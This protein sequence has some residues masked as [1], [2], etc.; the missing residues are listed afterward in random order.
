MLTSLNEVGGDRRPA[1]SLAGF[2]PMQAFDQNKPL[3]VGSHE[4]RRL[5]PLLHDALGKGCNLLRIECLTPPHRH[6]DICDCKRLLLH[7][8]NGSGRLS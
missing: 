3:A 2:Q 6:I 7:H 4:N 1:E 8:P 5:L